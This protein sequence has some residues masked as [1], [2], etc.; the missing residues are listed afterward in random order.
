MRT[1]PGVDLSLDAYI[2]DAIRLLQAS[3]PTRDD[4]EAFPLYGCFSGGKDSVVIKELVRLSGVPCDW[5]YNVTTID[6]PELTRF[7]RAEHPD[8]NW[9][10]PKK[11]FFARAKEKKVFPTRVCRWCCQEI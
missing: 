11:P 5:N 6:P 7:I 10:R 3:D 2:D 9:L 4:P 1:L 8:V